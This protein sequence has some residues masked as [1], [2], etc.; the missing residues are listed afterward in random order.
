MDTNKLLGWFDPNATYKAERKAKGAEG[1]A[2]RAAAPPSV[3]VQ[4]LVFSLG[5]FA[6]PFIRQYRTSGDWQ[7]LTARRVI[8]AAVFSLLTGFVLFPRVMDS[9]A[10]PEASTFLR[11]SL[12]FTAG[13]GWEQISG[14]PAALATQG[15]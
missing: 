12:V 7:D 2:R 5:V 13:M 1:Q 15:H 3:F 10:K 14:L 8:G 9:I 4:Y 6:G 11:L